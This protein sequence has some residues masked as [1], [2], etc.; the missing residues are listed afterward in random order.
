VLTPVSIQSVPSL[1]ASNRMLRVLSSLLLALPASLSSGVV[2]HISEEDI[3]GGVIKLRD[4]KSD[5]SESL[6]SQ[7]F[8]DHGRDIVRNCRL[9]E[10]DSLH[11]Y[12]SEDIEKMRNISLSDYQGSIS[13]V[14]NLAS[15]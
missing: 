4:G 9:D 5:S 15:F 6:E 1:A 10:S 8:T 2:P 14:V 12:A 13:L 11:N 7:G 3:H